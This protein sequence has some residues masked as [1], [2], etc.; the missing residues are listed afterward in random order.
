MDKAKLRK[1]LTAYAP[2]FA[3]ALLLVICCISSPGFRKPQNLLNITRQV[4]YSGIIA[5]GMTFIIIG[6]GIDIQ[7]KSEVYAFIRSLLSQGM[8]CILISS[9]LEEIIGIC[10]R[11][12]V[13]RDGRIAGFLEEDKISEENIMYLASGVSSN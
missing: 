11:V 6:G 12:A 1:T 9:D 3:L 5:L 13:M 8:A 4:S 7:A 2:Y 10:R